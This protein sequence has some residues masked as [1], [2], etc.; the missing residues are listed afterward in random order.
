MSEDQLPVVESLRR[1]PWRSAAIVALGILIFSLA[2]SARRY[3]LRHSAV[4]AW[5]ARSSV[6]ARLA[7]TT[8]SAWLVAREG[9]TRMLTAAASRKPE[10]FGLPAMPDSVATPPADM[11]KSLTRSLV[12]L[13]Q[14]HSY[15]AVWF[16]DRNG[17]VSHTT[18][19]GAVPQSV[20]DVARRALLA[21]S[22]MSY[23]LYAIRANTVDIAFAQP[24]F[25]HADGKRNGEVRSTRAIGVVVLTTSA[26]PL[27]KEISVWPSHLP[28]AS[29]SI[30]VDGRDSVYEFGI[31][32]ESARGTLRGRWVT[33]TAPAFTHATFAASPDTS[34]RLTAAGA[35]LSTR[36]AGLPW[37]LVLRDSSAAVFAEVNG[38]LSTEASTTAAAIFMI[39]IIVIGRRQTVRERK[40]LEIAESEVRY[41]LL[42]DNSTDLIARHA[43]DGRILYVSPAVHAILGY[44]PRQMQGHYASEFFDESD[45]TSTDDILELLRSTSS[46]SRAE[47][48]LRHADGHQVWVETTG[49]AVRDPV[50]GRVT[51]IVTVSRDI[52][53][54]KKAEEALRASEEDYRMLFDMH[55]Q[56]MWAFDADTLRFVAVNDEAVAYYGYSREEFLELTILDI[57][58]SSD[59]DA[60]IQRVSNFGAGHRSFHGLQHRTK[61]GTLIDVD[62]TVHEVQLSGRTTRLAVVT[63]VTEARRTAT[64]LRESNEL[65]RA[66]FDS[67][68]IAIVATAPDLTVLQWNGAAERL[69]GWTA[70][71]VVGKPY[72]LATADMLP[73]V[74]RLNQIALREG[75]NVDDRVQRIRKDGSTVELSVSVGVIRDAFLQPA[76][77][78]LLAADVS[79]RIK[80][81]AQLLHAQKMDAVGQLAGGIAHDFNNLLTVVTGYAGMMLHDLP[82]DSPM[83][84]DIQEIMGAADRASLL[85][86][87]L[88]AF[89]RQQLLEPRVLD[90]N[91][92]VEDMQQM[93]RR[94][95]PASIRFITDL[96]PH[97][98]SVN[99]DPGQLELVLMN[100][101]VN[102]RDAMPAGGT[103]KIETRDIALSSEEGID[104]DVAPGAY[105]MIAVSDTG[106]GIPKSVEPRIFEPFFTTKARDEGTGLGLSTAHGI[107]TQSGGCISVVT[108]PGHGATFIV[109][110]PNATVSPDSCLETNEPGIA[111]TR[112]NDGGSHPKPLKR[113]Q[114]SRAE[115]AVILLVEDDAPVRL[116]TTRVLERA[117]YSV[118]AA[119]NGHDALDIHAREGSRISL[120]ISDMIM[121]EMSGLVFVR[122]VRGRDSHIPVLMMSGYIDDEFRGTT[123]DE[124]GADFI[125]K[126]FGADALVRKVRASIDAAVADAV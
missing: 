90:L 15:S 10:F 49:R 12:A 73:D 39:A 87:Q 4:E 115:V 37:A 16:F 109:L 14:S 53:D 59:I 51:E 57:R 71:E 50:W 78:V 36:L 22:G 105:V 121:P 1:R 8:A 18:A 9:D 64:A 34:A 88:L 11:P 69:F 94:V 26:M 86:R 41:K 123:A 42:A 84:S 67:S 45:P 32:P 19:V 5:A 27:L 62:L 25:V 65:V 23:G 29:S 31:A 58:P 17:N 119:S 95:L 52:E 54:R 63:D 104:H 76:G 47:H 2:V 103:L 93:L 122:S 89:S 43:P 77:F 117:G 113:D 96:E 55:P 91:A 118:L 126:P 61:D 21:D 112:V 3:T 111:A 46:V 56:P 100:L 124:L 7:S 20:Q 107:V 74:H 44:F 38:K 125:Q 28:G 83:R 48:R 85:T 116:T 13:N 30:I 102:A 120:I 110:L 68:P 60:A 35:E 82:Q 106:C 101:I 108:E 79:E 114:F 6:V 70:E 33:K 75:T 98:G 81:E 92:V 72:P 40:L 66:L 24:V 99:A 80:L 97:L